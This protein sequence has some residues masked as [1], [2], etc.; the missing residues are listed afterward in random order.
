MTQKERLVE[1]IIQSIDGCARHWAEVIADHLLS[2][3]VIVPPCKVGDSVW[4]VDFS[5]KEIIDGYVEEI[6]YKWVYQQETVLVT[7]RMNTKRGWLTYWR[8][9]YAFGDHVFLSKAEAEQA[10]KERET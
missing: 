8:D 9:F 1:L 7:M 2:N 6:S 4:L 10:L 5:N 3:G